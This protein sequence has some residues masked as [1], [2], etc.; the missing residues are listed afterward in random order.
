MKSSYSHGLTP[1][2]FKSRSRFDLSHKHITSLNVGDLIPVMIQEVLPGDTFKVVSHNVFRTSTP[3]VKPVMDNLFFDQYFFFVPLRL[4]W[5][6]LK[7]FFGENTSGYWAQ[8]ETPEHPKITGEVASCSIADYLGIPPFVYESGASRY[9]NELPF[10][11]F[12]LIYNEWFRDQNTQ[13][14]VFITKSDGESNQKLNG[15]PWSTDNIYGM[16]PKINKLHDYFTSCLPAP[17]KGE[18]ITLKFGDSSRVNSLYNTGDSGEPLFVQGEGAD[19]YLESSSGSDVYVNLKG[20][21]IANV[22]DLRMAFAM[23]RILERSARSGSRYIE[24]IES[25]FGVTNPDY[26]LQRPEYLG[27]KRMPLNIQQ[28]A[29]TVQSDDSDLGQVGAYSLSNGVCGFNKGFT[30]HG[31]IIS[32]GAIRY[33]HTYQQGVER[34][35]TY[36][37]K[38]DYYDPAFA[39]IGEQPVYKSELDIQHAGLTNEDI[40]GYNE[41]WAHLRY[42]PNR[43]S[44]QMRTASGEGLDIW[45][46]AD[47]YGTEPFLNADFMKETEKF[48]DRTLS[49]PSSTINNFIVDFYHQVEAVRCLPTFS[50]PGLIDHK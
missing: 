23:Q 27:G 10:R 47:T 15:L 35:L 41:A 42:K 38:L 25:A 4:V 39:N 29:S 40:F 19:A 1:R 49:A 6:E 34:F 2:I 45:H 14:P 48:V 20:I 5:D 13:E 32:V 30:E 43:V 46:F 36:T 33:K 26:R 28:V 9:F 22:N 16:P 31:F 7:Q 12:A 37:D 21:D 18:A 44:G 24:Y 17:Q 50:I 11:A 8:T 3:F